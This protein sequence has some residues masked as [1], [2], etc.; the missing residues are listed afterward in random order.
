M[1]ICRTAERVSV[2][3]D[4][5]ILVMFVTPDGEFTARNN[6]ESHEIV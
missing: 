4:S 6:S 5:E 3:S 1:R 2:V